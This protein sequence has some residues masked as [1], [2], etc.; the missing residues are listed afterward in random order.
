MSKEVGVAEAARILGVRPERARQLIAD[1]RLE[2][3]RV[4][5]RW[6]VDVASLPSAP[7]RGRPMSQRIAWAFVHLGEGRRAPWIRNEEAYRLRSRRNALV[8]DAEPEL[9]LRSWLASRAHRHQLSGPSAERLADDPRV[10]MSGISDARSG[11]SA[12]HQAEAYVHVDDL[13]QVCADHLLVPARRAD[14]NVWLHA[15]PTV[16]PEPVPVLLVAADLAD[17]DGPRELARARELI[18]Q[19]LV[20]EEVT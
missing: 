9:L 2:A 4:A 11:I 3:R 16:P 13:E 17:H 14:A 18:V 19:A 7:R 10:S 15:A 20:N 1:G 5:G 8:H 6:A 12:G